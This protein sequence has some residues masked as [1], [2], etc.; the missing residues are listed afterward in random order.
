MKLVYLEEKTL[1]TSQL[2]HPGVLVAENPWRRW[3]LVKLL[4]VAFGQGNSYIS[5]SACFLVSFIYSF[6]MNECLPS[7]NKI[8]EELGGGER[9]RQVRKNSYGAPS[10]VREKGK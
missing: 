9:R 5:D 10:I 4:Y 3:T 2:A 1:V 7:S 6:K 8:A